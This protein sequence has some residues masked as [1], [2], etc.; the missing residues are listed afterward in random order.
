MRVFPAFIERP[1]W[2]RLGDLT[3][4]SLASWLLFPVHRKASR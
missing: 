4:Q 2:S 3:G 1:V